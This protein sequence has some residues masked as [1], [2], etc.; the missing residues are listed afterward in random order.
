MNIILLGPPGCGK[1]TQAKNL[2][3]KYAIPQISTGDI[4]RAAVKEKTPLGLQAKVCMDKGE[5]VPDELVVRIVDERLKAR[6]C[7]QGFIL[8]GFPRTVGQAEAL[9]KA[10]VVID[11]AVN[12]DVPDG[13]IMQRLTGRWT[14]RNC[15]AMYHSVFTPPKK[16]GVCDACQGAL[17]QRDDDKEATIQNRLVVYKKQTEPLIQ[18][19]STKRNLYSVQGT[20]TVEDIFNR[21]IAI[22]N[23][24]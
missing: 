24:L 14:C 4:L 15:S 19:Y 11:G 9:E 3:K 5:L 2:A 8:D 23:T 7:A 22:L 21:I 13:E 17:Y 18:W 1:G 10:G 6:D 12:I 20:G 16:Q